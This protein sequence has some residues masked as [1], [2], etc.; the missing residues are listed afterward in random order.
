M[1]PKIYSTLKSAVEDWGAVNLEEALKLWDKRIVPAS[2]V[3]YA[4]LQL[5]GLE[6]RMDEDIITYFTRGESYTNKPNQLT[7]H[8]IALKM[9]NNSCYDWSMG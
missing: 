8:K 5:S 7:L 4:V 2:V 9:T 1:D 6:Q 3:S